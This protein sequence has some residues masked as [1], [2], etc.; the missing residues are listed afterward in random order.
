MV[1]ISKE[2]SV[3]GSYL[4]LYSIELGTQ[5]YSIFKLSNLA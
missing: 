5:S 1:Y 3:K 4:I 2:V